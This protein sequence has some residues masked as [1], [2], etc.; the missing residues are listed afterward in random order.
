MEQLLSTVF[1]SIGYH[2]YVGSKKGIYLADYK[3]SFT[4]RNNVADAIREEIPKPAFAFI[5]ENIDL[6]NF[7]N[8]LFTAADKA[9]IES[10]DF[11]NLRFIVNSKKI[12]NIRDINNHFRNIN[13]L[14]PDAGI[15]I[16]R[17]YNLWD[18]KKRI[19]QKFGSKTGRLLWLLDFIINRVI[20]KLKYIGNIY[21]FISGGNFHILSTSEVLGRLF[22]CGFE[23]IDTKTVEGLT[24]FIAMKTK[25]PSAHPNPTYHPLVKLQ[26]IGKNGELIGIYKLRSMFPYSEYLQD[27]IVKMNGYNEYGKPANDFRLTGWGKIFRKLW[28]DEIPQIINV[29][30]GE[31]GI[32]GVRPLSKARFKELPDD[33]KKLRIKYKPGLIPPYVSLNMPDSIGNIEAEIIYLKQKLINPKRTDMKFFFMAMFNIFTGKVRSA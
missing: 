31:L 18:R 28:L 29:L 7:P 22:Y 3:N 15:Y 33:V 6:R 12:N 4:V 5:S 14:L 21:K 11:D 27:Y 32:V 8:I 10:L 17:V 9:Y 26:R 13:R 25:E 23:V 2:Q 20:P 24:Y 1:K 16:G 30:R 19:Y